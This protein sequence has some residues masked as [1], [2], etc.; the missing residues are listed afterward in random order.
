MLHELSYTGFIDG[1]DGLEWDIG[2]VTLRLELES[3]L[4]EKLR[5]RFPGPPEL[6]VDDLVDT[7]FG[8]VENHEGPSLAGYIH[9]DG[10]EEQVLELL[11]WRSVYHL[12]ETD[13]S[14]FVL[15]RLPRPARAALAELLYDEYGAGRPE[16]LHSHLFA[17]ALR[18]VGL[19]PDHGYLDEVPL[20][21]LEMNNAITMFGLHRR[22]RGAAMG[23]LA[24]FECTS[25][26]P[27]SR[28]VRGLQRL[29]FAQPVIDYYDEHVLADAVH[30]QVAVRNILLPLVQAEPDQLE[31]VFLGAFTCLDQEARVARV[32]LDRWGVAA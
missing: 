14:T 11:R 3:A 12:K 2:L 13:P 17:Q 19:D 28:L 24:A 21:V 7:F 1:D 22:L 9:T 8:Y 16:R 27:S 18:S 4:E 31:Q 32:L 30:E 26:I 10:T 25:S 15:A 23:H 29:G 6:P 20:E 5:D